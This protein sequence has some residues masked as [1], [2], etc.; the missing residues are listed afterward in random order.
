[1]LFSELINPEL[2]ARLEAQ[3]IT[4][5]TPIQVESLPHTLAG[6]DLIGRARTGTG[7]TLAF[8][9]PI[10]QSLE[11]SRER[12][13]TP[14]ALI[15]APTRELAKQVA[16]HFN[17]ASG[18]L[19]VLTIYGGAAYGPQEKALSRGVDI[20]VG[21]PGRIIDHI[22]RRNLMLDAVQFVVLDEADEMLSVGFADAIEEILKATP[23]ERQ[24]MLFSA[25]LTRDILRIA[26][27]YQ[28]DPVTVDLVGEGKSQAAVS[29]EHL[30][31]RVGRTRTRLLADL[32]TVYNPERAIIFTRTKREVDELAME[33]IHRGLEA[34]ALHGDLAQSQRERALG[35]FR[36]G[37]VRVL[38]ATDVAARGLDIPEV[39]LVVQYHLPQDH[40]SYVHRSGRT[41]RAGRT[42]TA[43]VMYGDREQRDLRNLEHATGVHFQERLHP[44]PKEVRDASASTAADQVRK[45]DSEFAEPFQQ[46]AERLFS[47]LGIEGLARAL[48]RIAGAVTAA[49]SVSLLSGEEGQITVM[50]RGQRLSVARTVALIAR[51]TDIDSRALGKVRLFQ[52]G[53]VADLPSELVAK[54]LA[55][56]PLDDQIEVSVPDELPELTDA[57]QRER[58]SD[59]RSGGGYRG[60]SRQGGGGGGSRFSND[61]GG[62]GGGSGGSNFRGR[63]SSS[64]EDFGSREFVPSGPERSGSSERRDRR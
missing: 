53:A 40:E 57:P 35:A 6:R 61:R 4:E 54:L 49:R 1:M 46:A 42:G 28:N 36:A 17:K 63:S 7:K 24:T 38:V 16:E 29:V 22:E 18:N 3:G 31:I 44:T 60:G 48:A 59:S 10:I 37:R 14:R 25:T 5:A 2:A 47:E 34:E 58:F 62:N 50:L 30:K 21:T 15:M 23:P 19:E 20:V 39:D 43:I 64:R 12:G 26:K 45:V 9:L 56:S 11:P 41:G 33:L 32:L 52:D 51:S 8:A 55:A 13:R 27:Q